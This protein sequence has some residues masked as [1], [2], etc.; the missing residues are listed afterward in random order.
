M[1]DKQTREPEIV[2][3]NR[4]ALGWWV[5][6]NPA[7]ALEAA[8]LL[9]RVSDGGANISIDGIRLRVDGLPSLKMIE[10]AVH[11]A[12]STQGR[13]TLTTEHGSPYTGTLIQIWTQLAATLSVNGER[14]ITVAESWE[15]QEQIGATVRASLYDGD[16][17]ITDAD[18]NEL[19]VNQLYQRA[20]AT[21]EISQLY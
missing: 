3:W 2:V 15:H 8:R 16:D 14:S 5:G 12:K 9:C 6:T 18:G 11:V 19:D 21:G 10:W 1:T 13:V 20:I 7:E 4:N 17:E